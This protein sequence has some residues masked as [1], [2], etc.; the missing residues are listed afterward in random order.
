MEPNT[1]TTTCPGCKSKNIKKFAGSM[2]ECKD[3][4]QL[5]DAIKNLWV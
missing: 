1:G 4:A 3:C 5:W 2:W